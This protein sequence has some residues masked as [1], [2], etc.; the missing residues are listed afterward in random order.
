M[1]WLTGADESR[2]ELPIH[3]G[4]ERIGIDPLAG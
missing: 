4:R 2:Q 1:E 3:L